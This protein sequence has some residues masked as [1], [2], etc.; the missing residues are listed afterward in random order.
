MVQSETQ[1]RCDGYESR[2]DARGRR[3]VIARLGIDAIGRITHPKRKAGACV[4]AERAGGG[5]GER[6]AGGHESGSAVE[7]PPEPGLR[8]RR[9]RA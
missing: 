4:A 9:R 5:T 3:I 1:S 6:L 2:S 8:T 7:S